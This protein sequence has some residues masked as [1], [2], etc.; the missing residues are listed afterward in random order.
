MI[1]LGRLLGKARLSETGT[2]RAHSDGDGPDL[3]QCRG[4]MPA[5]RAYSGLIESCCHIV[6]PALV[7]GRPGPFPSRGAI[8]MPAAIVASL[9][10]GQSLVS[11][12]L[13]FLHS[14]L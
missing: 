7:A 8:A 13:Q 5:S 12:L 4:V 2:T 14:M 3:P 1:T 11:L 10:D 9:G 6:M